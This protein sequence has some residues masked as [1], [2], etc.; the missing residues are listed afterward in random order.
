M[1]FYNPYKKIL[2][3]GVI[4]SYFF[5]NNL[6]S[7]DVQQL[8]VN[9]ISA[10]PAPGP[11]PQGLALDGEDVWV[12]DDSTKMIYKVGSY[13]G[14]V[15]NSFNAPGPAPKGLTF[16]STNLWSLDDSL[17]KIFKLNRETGLVIDAL[18]FP[19]EVNYLSTE[20]FS[21]FGLT[22][23]GEFLYI[24]FDAGWSSQIVRMSV[25]GD[26]VSSFCSTRGN[27]KDLTFDGKYFWNCIDKEGAGKGMVDRYDLNGM[28][29]DYFDTPAYYPTGITYDGKYYWI[30]DQGT[31]SLYQMQVEANV[32]RIEILPNNC[33]DYR[34]HQ[35]Y[36]NP[37]NVTTIFRYDVYKSNTIF[38]AIYDVSGKCVKEL[39]NEKH[40]P[41]QYQIF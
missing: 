23:D 33:W 16:D 37:F 28:R 1:C 2:I 25:N 11:S 36:P 29:L 27:S 21:F 38:L 18:N 4:C 6:I 14:I 20:G 7:Q 32:G 9:I 13:N 26:S 22:W 8:D 10:I 19:A 15:E 3:F 24:N 30:A 5:C 17:R 12:A 31:D 34:L 40:N 35:N 39:I 41:G